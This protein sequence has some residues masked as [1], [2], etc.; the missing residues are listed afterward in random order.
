MPLHLPGTFL[1]STGEKQCHGGLKPIAEMPNGIEE[2]CT[3]VC[4][5]L[6]GMT[7]LQTQ[8]SAPRKQEVVFIVNF[9][10]DGV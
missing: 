10:D 3:D 4:D 2:A 9:G 5:V 1:H 7:L 6:T 8:L